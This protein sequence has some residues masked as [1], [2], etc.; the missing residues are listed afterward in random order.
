MPRKKLRRFD[1]RFGVSEP[2]LEA[3][4]IYVGQEFRDY[5]L[6]SITDL[7]KWLKVRQTQIVTTEANLQLVLR[8]IPDRERLAIRCMLT[9]DFFHIAA[10]YERFLKVPAVAD[11]T[12]QAKL[13]PE[14]LTEEEEPVAAVPF[15]E[16]LF[17]S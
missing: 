4:G 7:R 1:P 9:R 14:E 11:A 3:E 2:M 12:G 5:L 16:W 8:S 13:V 15:S 6:M 10:L 17:E